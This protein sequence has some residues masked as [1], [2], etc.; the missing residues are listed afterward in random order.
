MATDLERFVEAEGRAEL[1]KDVRKRIDAEGVTYVYYQFVSVTGR[2]MGK[3]VPAPHWETIAREGLPARLRLDGEPVHGSPRQL[4]RL[5]PRG[6]GARRHPGAGDL[7]GA[8]V[9]HAGRPCLVHLLPQPRGPR[10]AG[11]CPHVGLPREPPPDPGGVR[12]THGHAPPRRDGARDDV[13]EARPRRHALDRGHDEAVLLPHRPVLRAPA[14]HPQGD[15]VRTEARPRHD[16][17][18]PRGRARPDRAQLPLRPGRADCGQ[19]LDLQADLQAGRPRARCVPVLHA[20]AVHGGLRQRLPHEHLALA[21]RRERLPSRH[22]RHAHAE[23][24]GAARSRR[25]P[26]APARAHLRHRLDGEL[27]PPLLGDGLLGAGLRR[28]GVSRTGR[29]HSGSPRPTASSTARWTPP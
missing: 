12:G 20:Q 28:L 8:A 1:V 27:L 19:P 24:D 26:R 2:I 9:G 4:H 18:R 23:P 15:R 5:R 14:D 16:P 29:P 21:G 10:R 22:G 13:A 11:R 3:G 6:L 25:H 7:R 17:G